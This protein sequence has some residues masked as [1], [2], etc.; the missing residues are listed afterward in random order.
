[1]VSRQSSWLARSR[2]DWQRRFLANL[3]R[4]EAVARVRGIDRDSI[5]RAFGRVDAPELVDAY[6]AAELLD[7]PRLG[8]RSD[9]AEV[10]AAIGPLLTKEPEPTPPWLVPVGR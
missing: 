10:R 9:P 2:A 7:L 4:A 8:T 1:M 5:R 6:D 3:D